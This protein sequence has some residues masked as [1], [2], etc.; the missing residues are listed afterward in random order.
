MFC[1]WLFTTNICV[2]RVKKS[3]IPQINKVS[4]F[5]GAE[6]LAILRR[7]AAHAARTTKRDHFCVKQ[8][9]TAPQASLFK[10]HKL[11]FESLLKDS[12]SI[13]EGRLSVSAESATITIR[14]KRNVELYTVTVKIHVRR[15]LEV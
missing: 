2:I 5:I 6:H 10:D 12:C 3:I 15:D 7:L 13:K 8:T 1:G 9:C 11:P 4:V 14:K